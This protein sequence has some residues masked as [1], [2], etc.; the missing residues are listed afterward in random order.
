MKIS[1]IMLQMSIRGSTR[2]LKVWEK[3]PLLCG[4]HMILQS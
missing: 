3:A 2:V 4:H 1:N